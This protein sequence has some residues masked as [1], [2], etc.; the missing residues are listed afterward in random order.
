MAAHSWTSASDL[1][2]GRLEEQFPEH[3]PLLSA[4]EAG[5]EAN[6]CLFCFQAPCIAACPTGIDIP[7]FIKKIATGNLAGS[8]RT[9]LEANLLGYSCGRVCPVEVLCVGACVY[10]AWAQ[11]P[12]AIGR[13]QRYATEHALASGSG[14]LAT[15]PRR[16][17][18]VALVGGGPASLS[19]AG[20]LALEG[21]E[22]VIY[23]RAR[24]GGGLNTLGIAPYKMPAADALREVAFIESLGVRLETGVEVGEDL[25]VERLFEEFDAIFLGIGLGGDSRL[26][27]PGEEGPGVVGA[28][29]LIERVKHD[30][31]LRLAPSTR[32]VVVGGGNTAIDAAREL[33][34]LGVHVT[35]AYR[36]RREQMPAYDHEVEQALAEGAHLMVERVPVAVVRQDGQLVAL[37][38]AEAREG[39]PISGTESEIPADLLVVA[40]GQTRLADFVSRFPGVELDGR[41]RIVADPVTGRT[42]HPRVYAGGDCVNGGK[43]VVNAVAAGRD[44]ARAILAAL[45]KQESGIGDQG[46]AADVKP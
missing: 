13:L 6:R 9:I 15:K 11:R 40:I 21:V 22:A 27:V 35:I 2:A 19:C 23:E 33:A 8:A 42:G 25:P 16:P 39:R 46:R 31:V 45:E 24:W 3:E 5:A 14:V 36:R 43:E 29:R 17:G 30:P 4:A 32:A 37:R 41:S 44:A 12:I 38:I 26:R 18:R 10:N 1:P 7:R 34:K 28:T 20:T